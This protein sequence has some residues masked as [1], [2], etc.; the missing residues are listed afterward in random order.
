M[1]RLHL[2][3]T[4]QDPVSDMYRDRADPNGSVPMSNH[5]TDR[6]GQTRDPDPIDIY[7]FW[8]PL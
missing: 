8:A 3:G 1:R 7:N 5:E 4:L 6:R 2:F